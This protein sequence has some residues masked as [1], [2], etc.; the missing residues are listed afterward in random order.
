MS[1][2][3]MIRAH[4]HWTEPLEEYFSST[5][6]KAH[7]L[8]WCHKRSEELYSKRRTYID[9]PVIIGSGLIGF[10]NAGSTT[11]FSDAATSSIALGLGSLSIGVLNSVSTYFG[12]AK[13]AEGHRIS[14]I[15]YSRLYRALHVQMTLPR[16]ERMTPEELLRYTK[17]AY[18]RLQETSPLVPPEIIRTFNQRF[19][20][21]KEI[22]KPEEVNGLEKIVA[23]VDSRPVIRIPTDI[24]TV[25]QEQAAAAAHISNNPRPVVTRVDLCP[26]NSKP[27]KL[28]MASSIWTW[29]WLWQNK[30][31]MGPNI[32]TK[33]VLVLRSLQG[34]NLRLPG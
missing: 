33:R 16:G 34:L 31:G 20:H 15:E 32:K 4:I 7:C 24:G 8:S 2:T 26:M 3:E 23:F 5:G 30:R 6:E 17:D 1:D 22:S 14:S 9:L 27:R 11:L 12:W 25:L 18:D 13:R 29:A 19:D 10:L 28:P 21:E